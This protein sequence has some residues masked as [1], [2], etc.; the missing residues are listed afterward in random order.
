MSKK[1]IRGSREWER[2][3]THRVI[4]HFLEKYEEFVCM[5]SMSDIEYK[6]SKK[7]KV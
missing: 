1:G 6:Y 2:E 3:C 7:G 5:Q 4:E